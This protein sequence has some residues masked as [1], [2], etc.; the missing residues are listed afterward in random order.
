M[1]DQGL[2]QKSPKTDDSRPWA[3]PPAELAAHL[4]A[5]LQHGLTT[6]EA[7]RRAREFGPNQIQH[8]SQRGWVKV[9]LAQFANVMVALLVVAAVISLVI[10]EW[11]DALLI[12]LIVI[13]NAIV[14]F[15]QEWTAERAIETLR[16]MTEPAAKV[17]RDG[18]WQQ[19]PAVNLVV[20]D[21]IE[22]RTGDM[23]PADARLAVAVELETS[24][25]SLTGE[26]SPV[27]KDLEPL[28]PATPLPDRAC[29]LYCG[30]SVVA[31]HGHALVTQIGSQTELGRIAGMLTTATPAATPLQ[32]QLDRLSQQLTVV[33]VAAAVIMFALGFQRH[34]LAKMLLTAV[35]LAVAALPE[36]L[37]AVITIG[38]AIGAKRMARRNAIIRRL[39][40]VE[41]LGSVNV[42]CTDKTG[43]LTQNKMLV[44]HIE[45]ATSSADHRR[46]LLH[47]AVL[48]NDATVDPDGT[49]QGS[50][51]ECAF[52]AMALEEGIKLD[53]VRGEFERINELPFTSARKRMATLHQ[54]QDGQILFVKGA[55]EYVLPSC[56][57]KVGSSEPL[58]R[59]EL[60]DAAA[61]LASRGNRVLAFARRAW[62]AA[63]PSPQPEEW[64]KSLEYLGA[65]ALSDPVRPEVPDA[66][67]QCRSAGILPVLITGDHP[68][69][70]RAIAEQLGIWKPGERVLTGAELDQMSPEQLQVAVRDTTV[71]ARVSP[72]HKLWIVRGHQAGGSVTSMTG[73]GVN[74]APALKQADIG[75]AMGRNGTDVAKEAS[76]MVLSDD[77]FATIVA[78]VEEGRAVYDNIRKSVAYLIAGNT[79]EVLLL[80]LALVAGFPLPLFP[81]QI[82]WINLVTDGIPA[83]AMAFEPP[84]AD[85]MRRVPRGRREGLFGQGLFWGVL[86]VGSSLAVSLLILFRSMLTGNES[87]DP[88]AITYAQTAVFMTLALAELVYATSARDLSRGFDVAGLCRNRSLLLAIVLGIG[89][90]FA[91]CYV[92]QL[93]PIFHTVSLSARDLALCVGTSLTGFVAFEI[94]KR[95]HARLT[96][97]PTAA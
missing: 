11:T 75:V 90:Q 35:G 50:P 38:L 49:V 41:T 72:A 79:A 1:S 66:I 82:L 26:S 40:A 16:R 3:T 61:A 43:T 34:G 4:K 20:G 85:V 65:I 21:L 51:T 81:I 6:A 80:F 7:E 93:Q 68:E 86:L 32:R 45:A 27:V 46:D 59:Q 54:S 70:A 53:E 33:I 15:S 31:G 74:D 8:Q 29:M 28:P 23:V 30:T 73:D 18:Q 44:S 76:A 19:I 22:V 63:E 36:G 83:L 97:T 91:V 14:G 78:A 77:N 39:T 12:C 60:L 89:L 69:T 87:D 67:Q 64:G 88:A 94:W 84:E 95:L 42:I 13:A 71:Y 47:A 37:P 57:R 17:C 5:D 96:P 56:D 24:E 10:G 52:L 2:L 55:I 62:S 92:P 9:F 48:C 58:P 25:A